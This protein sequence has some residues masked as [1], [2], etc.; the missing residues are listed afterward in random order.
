MFSFSGKIW[1]CPFYTDI[2]V[3][4]CIMTCFFWAASALLGKS[5]GW[6][7]KYSGAPSGCVSCQ[8]LST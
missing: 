7:R 5:C 8:Q 6:T 4:N 2:N 1:Y 3:F